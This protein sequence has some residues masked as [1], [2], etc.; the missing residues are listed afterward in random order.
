MRWQP[1][2]APPAL[3]GYYLGI[4]PV[5]RLRRARRLVR[6]SSSG[7]ANIFVVWSKN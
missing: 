2:Y 7:E 5:E 3:K 6:C 4:L 1:K